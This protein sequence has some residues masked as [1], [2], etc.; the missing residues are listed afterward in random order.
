MGNPMTPLFVQQP[1]TTIPFLNI[2]SATAS[3]SA[4]LISAD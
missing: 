3:G 4:D 2:A 1:I